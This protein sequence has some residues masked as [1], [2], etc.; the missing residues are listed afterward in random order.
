MKKLFLVLLA[1]TTIS[2]II[3]QTIQKRQLAKSS[4]CRIAGGKFQPS[5]KLVYYFSTEADDPSTCFTINGGSIVSGTC[6]TFVF[7]PA[8][9]LDPDFPRS[10]YYIK[11]S[12]GDCLT[13]QVGGCAFLPRAAN[14][15][16]EQQWKVIRTKGANNYLFT[17]PRMERIYLLYRHPEDNRVMFL[18][19]QQYNGQSTHLTMRSKPKYEYDPV[20][21]S[22]FLNKK[23]KSLAF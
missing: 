14:L 18:T 1:L 11:R 23:N 20:P 12:N 3:A 16:E 8:V 5:D 7:E 10:L 4:K 15:A 13:Y 2:I 21:R 6:E 17:L 9:S 19:C 22:N